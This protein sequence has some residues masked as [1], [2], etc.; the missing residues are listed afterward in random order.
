MKKIFFFI[1]VVSC[2]VLY[3]QPG[4]KV[5]ELLRD[6]YIVEDGNYGHPYTLFDK[7]SNSLLLNLENIRNR[8]N[9]ENS[10]VPQNRGPIFLA[11]QKVYD[12]ALSPRPTDDGMPNTGISGLARWAKSNAFVMLVGL[13]GNGDSLSLAG[14]DSFK[15]RV[16]EA[17]ENMTGEIGHERNLLLRVHADLIRIIL[18]PTEENVQLLKDEFELKNTYQFHTRSHILWLEAYDLL[19]A[20]AALPELNSI[21]Y[22][23][24][25]DSD[26]NIGKSSPRN[27][28]R[29][30]TKELYQE[31]KGLFGMATHIWGWKK[32]HGIACASALLLAAQV[33]N[34]AGVEKDFQP[35]S[36]T[37]LLNFKIDLTLP[38]PNYS[39]IK[40]NDFAKE[41]L[42]E[43]L[44]EGKHWWPVPDNPVAPLNTL[45]DSYSPY[46]EGPV[47]ST[48]GLGDCGI[49]A[50]RAQQN[51]Y[52][53]NSEEP[54]LK[55]NEIINI[56]R[57]LNEISVGSNDIPTYD[58]SRAENK[59]WLLALT[60]DRTMFRG[61]PGDFKDEFA[62]LIAIVGGN[63]I[64]LNTQPRADF[65]NDLAEVG[66]IIVKR[67]TEQGNYY[68]HMLAEEG[69]E[70]CKKSG[71]FGKGGTH[72]EPDLGGFFIWAG[73][74]QYSMK[75][76]GVDPP[77]LGWSEHESTNKYYMHNVIEI[78]NGIERKDREYKN[79]N[80]PEK[81][82]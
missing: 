79:P 82:R 3:A 50:M 15:N 78:D 20:S 49:P 73:N 11:Y 26:A 63:N 54:L 29:Y 33:L 77:S 30:Q 42:R 34:D 28:L 47:Y 2:V 19:K 37:G 81:K 55:K 1:G 12:N 44:F 10:P 56:F 5:K 27:K 69:V 43:N 8:I 76:L 21:K 74:N 52:P 41:A 58:G 59:S 46:S 61:T 35:I 51:F 23:N 70:V 17:F 65:N 71:L 39:P 14:R 4:T 24:N 60:N 13:N 22:Y 7:N 16:L 67:N 38:H 36:I 18:E 40:W 62:D 53:A 66:N 32:N 57:W 68:F 72:E 80:N 6:R 9:I 75:Q 48:Y 25:Y 31:S 45:K 64:P